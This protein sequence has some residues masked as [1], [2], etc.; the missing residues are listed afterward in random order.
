M[1]KWKQFQEIEVGFGKLNDFQDAHWINVVDN[2]FISN[3]IHTT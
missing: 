3:A 1:Q 2:N